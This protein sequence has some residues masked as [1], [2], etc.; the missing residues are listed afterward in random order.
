MGLREAAR[1]LCSPPSAFLVELVS[2]PEPQADVHYRRK[3]SRS[4]NYE[5]ELDALALLRAPALQQCGVQDIDLRTP[6]FNVRAA[7]PKVSG[8]G[9]EKALWLK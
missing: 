9:R 8:A 6:M 3:V 4:T 1:P 5:A 7:V 2:G